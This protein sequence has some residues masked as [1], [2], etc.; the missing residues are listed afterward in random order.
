[1]DADLNQLKTELMQNM[2]RIKS[3]QGL[4]HNA[5]G[6]NVGD[7]FILHMIECKDEVDGPCDERGLLHKHLHHHHQGHPHHVRPGLSQTLIQQ[8][9]HISKSAISQKLNA[10]EEKGLITREINKADRRRFDFTLTE[11]GRELT[12]RAQRQMDEGVKQIFERMGEQDLREL[13][14]LSG[15][16]ADIVETILQKGKEAE[17]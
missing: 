1:M 14:R 10:L 6:L 5:E 17:L 12:S 4:L 3:F 8:H 15:K 7:A 9:L 13:I 16:L 2:M 11:A